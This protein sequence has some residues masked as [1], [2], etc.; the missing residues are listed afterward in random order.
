RG[1]IG[2]VEVLLASGQG[3]WSPAWGIGGGGVVGSRAWRA[4]RALRRGVRILER[5]PRRAPAP[6]TGRSGGTRSRAQ[7]TRTRVGGPQ[8]V[9]PRRRAPGSAPGTGSTSR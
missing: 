6:Q 2:G 9:R 7:G 5:V 8:Q 1:G 3:A 4:A